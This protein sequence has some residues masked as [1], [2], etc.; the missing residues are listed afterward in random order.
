MQLLSRTIFAI[1]VATVVKC[2]VGNQIIVQVAEVI[3]DDKCYDDINTSGYSV[4]PVNICYA[5][6]NCLYISLDEALDNLTNNVLIN[7]TTNVTLS[8]PYEVSNLENVSI[9]GHNNPT[10]N[11]Q[12]S[13]GLHFIFC[14]NCI[15][16]GITWNRCGIKHNESYAKPGLKF[17]NSSDVT[18][19]YCSFQDFV[20]QIIVMSKISGNVN[21][22][23]CKFANN[24][25]YRGHGGAIH[26]SSDDTK[27]SL[28]FVITISNCNFSFNKMK[29][30]VYLDNSGL[31]KDNK[32]AYVNSISFS[33]NTGVPI[34]VINHE[35]YFNEKVLFQHNEAKYGAGIYIT[36]H[37]AVV[38]DKTSDI[39]FFANSAKCNG[40]AVYLNNSTCLFDKNSSVTF[41]GN[42]AVSYGGTIFSVN[43]SNVVFKESCK[44]RFCS[45][46]FVICGAAIASVQNS[47]VTFTDNAKVTFVNNHAGHGTLFSDNSHIS[48]AG[49][50]ITTFSNNIANDGGGAISIISSHLSFK[51]TSSTE[52]VNNTSYR[53]GGT[54]H[55]YYETY[56]SFEENS[57]AT[58]TST[59]GT[60][61]YL[62]NNNS[63]ISFKG[64]SSTTFNL[65]HDN[66]PYRDESKQVTVF[67]KGKI[68]FEGSSSTIFNDDI[69]FVYITL[70]A[71]TIIF[72]NNSVVTYNKRFININTG[73][74]IA[75]NQIIEMGYSKVVIN[76]HLLPWCTTCEYV[77]FSTIFKY[78]RFMGA[79]II[80][81]SDTKVHCSLEMPRPLVP[82]V[83][84][85]NK[86]Q[87]E[88]LEYIM[89]GG[90]HNNSLNISH[91]VV[92]LSSFNVLNFSLIGHNTIVYCNQS[93][94][95]QVKSNDLI[96]EGITWI[97]CGRQINGMLSISNCS[98]ITI[99]TCSFQFSEGQII[100]ITDGSRDVHINDCK[101]VSNK[102]YKDHGMAILSQ[103][104][105]FTI[106]NC[107][108]SSNEGG[109]SVIYFEQY[110]S[111]LL[112]YRILLINSSFC[113]N[114]GV[115]I[116][117]NH[118]CKLQISG[119]A[120]FDNNVAKHG[121]GIYINKQSTLVFGENSNATFINNHADGS[122]AAIL[123]NNQSSVLFDNN[124]IVMLINN[125][126]T[127]GIIY[128]KFNSN[129]KFK[130]VS[131]V[132]FSNNSAM[133]YG[134]SIYSIDSSHVL[135]TENSTVTFIG[136]TANDGEAVTLFNNSTATVEKHSILT[137]SNNVAKNSGGALYA[138]HNSDFHF[139]DKSI[140][141]FVNN[142]AKHHGET[143]YLR[144]NS[145]VTINSNVRMNG[146][147]ATW[148]YGSQLTNESNYYDIT[149]DANG[150]VRCSDHK[151]YYI[152]TFTKCSCKNLED[153]SSNSAVI[154]TG[155]L[156]LSSATTLTNIVNISITGY[157]NNSIFSTNDGGLQ[158]ISCKKVTITN[159]LFQHISR[160]TYN[161]MIP[162]I[163]LHN[164][165][166]VTI[167][168]CTFLLS[169][170]QEV[171]LSEVSDV[172]IKHC[173][174]E[175]KVKHLHRQ[176]GAAIHYSSNN[177]KLCKDQFLIDDCCF[178]DNSGIKSLIFLEHLNT[179][180][181]FEKIFIQNSK[182][183]KNHGT[184][185]HLL[186]QNLHVKGSLQFDSNL[187]ENG[188]SMFIDHHSNITFG[189]TANV[190]FSHNTAN[191]SGGA[192]YLNNWSSV[193]FE[194]YSRV[195]FFGNKAMKLGGSIYLRNNSSIT[196]R[197]DSK[198]QFDSNNAEMGG[199]LYVTNN[200]F[201]R[202]EGSSLFTISNSK[203]S[204][205][206]AIYC[207]HNCN[208]SIAKRST[209]T[210]FSNEVEEYGS[211]IYSDVNSHVTFEGNTNVTIN[212]NKAKQ[213]GAMYLCYKSD[214]TF[215]EH[216]TIQFDG[217]AAESGG[218]L[219]TEKNSSILVKGN[220]MLTINNSEAKQGGAIYLTENSK[221][222]TI[223][224]SNIAFVNNEAEADGG[225]IYSDLNSTISF[226]G[227]STI[228]I[229]DNRATHGG[230]FYSRQSNLE[231]GSSSKA[232]FDKN[233]AMETGGSINIENYSRIQFRGTCEVIFRN[234]TVTFY[235]GMGGAISCGSNSFALFEEKSKVI[236]DHNRASDGGA[237]NF[238]LNSSF[239]I[240]NNSIVKF[241]NN[242]A[243]TGGAV[244]VNSG[245]YCIFEGN[246]TLVLEHNVASNIGG[247]FHLKGESYI[248]FERQVKVKLNTSNKAA[249][250]GAIYCSEN[251]S[252]TFGNMSNTLLSENRA[253]NGGGIF[254]T[255]SEFIFA[256]HSYILFKN[257]TASQN[258]GAIY[259]NDDSYLNLERDGNV[260]FSH[261]TAALG[262][263]IHCSENSSITF[264]NMSNTL[265]FG[266]SAENGGGIFLA[267]S[268]FI[269]AMHSYI[270]FKNNTAS[271]DGGA[272]YLN[273]NSYLNL[274]RDCNVT[275]SHNTAALGGA[276][277]CSEN[278]S[279]TFGNMS[280]TLLSGNSA[281]NGGGIFLTNSE[282]KFAMHSYIV[283]KN[284]TA[285][286]D[287]GAI[288]LND[289]S[290]LNL[291]RD[292]NVTF[293]HNTAALGGAIHCSENSS[294]KFGNMSNTLLSGNSAENGGGIFL[295][296]SEFIF[297]IHSYTLFKNNTASQDGGA[298]YLNDDS[299]LNLERD[300]NVTF[301]HNTAALGGAIHCSE[302]S[303]ITFGNM[304][305]TLLS[306][307][308]AENG[309]GIFL[310]NSEF[311]FAM[312]SYILFKNNTASQ[313]GGAIYLNDDSHL[314]LERDC[315]VTF[316]HNTASYYGGAMYGKVAKSKINFSSTRIN[317]DSNSAGTEGNSVYITLPKQCN[318]D[319]LSQSIVGTTDNS[320][321]IT[322][323]IKIQFYNSNI[324]CI[325]DNANST[326]CNIYYIKNIMLGQQ[327]VLDACMYDYY[328]HPA[329]AARFLI[330]GDNTQGY[331][332]GS[333]NT[334]ISCNR[335]FELVNIHGN[336]STP[337]NY[338][339][340]LTLYDYCQ[341]ELRDVFTTLIV[342]L[343]SCHSGF[344]YNAVSQKC[345]CYNASDI[346]F[347]SGRSSTI[348]AGYWF[349]S[350]NGKSTVTTCPINYCDFTCCETSN[351][352]YQLSPERDDQ[353]RQHRFDVACGNCIDGYTLSFD[354]T[355]CVN[356]KSCTAGQTAL[357]ILLSMTYWAVMVMLV[358]AMMYYT[359]GIG[360][361]YSITYYYSIVDILLSQN[362]YASRGLYL[363][364]NIIS[365]FSKI[366]PQFLGE[367][368]LTTGMTGID[369]QFIH[370]IHPTAIILILILIVLL[371]KRSR[372][373]SAIIS[374]GIIHVICLLLLLSY[375]SIA[376]TSL[377]LMRPLTFFEIDNIYTYVSPNI[378][379]FHGR[380][381][382]YGIVALLCAVIV[383][384][385]LPFLLI[386][387]PFLNRKIDFIKIKP[388]LDQFQGCYKDQ[389]RCFAGYYMI[390]RL[391]I[392]TILIINSSN[393][394]SYMLIAVCGII[395]LVHVLVKPYNNKLLNRFDSIILQLII[396][397]TALPLFDDID[398]SLVITVTFVLVI[399]PLLNFIAM[400]LFLNKNNI[401]KI[402]TRFTINK[403]LTSSCSDD[404]NNNDIAMKEFNC[405]VDDSTRE[406]VKITV[407]DM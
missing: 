297:A 234:S 248:E 25:R 387:E 162:S 105:S 97:G 194:N 177:T 308:N 375:T 304:S 204:Y 197:E 188:A 350:V 320:Y 82:Y 148:N 361:L 324:K 92:S 309:G 120:L 106:N 123:M 374:R 397:I 207:T 363:T 21:I 164:S 38:F 343:S 307:N 168:N 284:N 63:Y 386:L 337:F 134:A 1:I 31:C 100:N 368:C 279:I 305:N 196:V 191:I 263:A 86:C 208:I 2:V 135:F 232:E 179:H 359:V 68:Y 358:F 9:I 47:H 376:S 291:E 351:G 224:N 227:N 353:C 102:N 367:L 167:E 303:S 37:S 99:Q 265:L 151:E 137:F 127:D 153:I 310:T 89:K 101:F 210:F 272:I 5:Y 294:I 315:N 219:H 95:L 27:N 129:I 155:D 356:I 239:M 301:S 395:S 370:Y 205:G 331:S 405:I 110:K 230:A 143:M 298:I 317:F 313:D 70:F 282:F 126:A 186:N 262:G 81:N 96:I 369:Q 280:I 26:F 11:C 51:G 181:C 58:F 378:E 226:E 285:S 23:D 347:C 149:I 52:F 163:K 243:I 256:M 62:D 302:S 246:S 244:N 199:T 132:I 270:L 286:Q 114:K 17:S 22:T 212:H 251:S 35:I 223:E 94:E 269:F 48:F 321:I 42:K 314:N 214:I 128:A 276:I 266:N 346:V 140:A 117:L 220:S 40:G 209:V 71:E 183:Y 104:S 14:Q 16:K 235:N 326:T 222:I 185:I 166:D 175:S 59:K 173:K 278:S 44:V 206:G 238:V 221:M 360:Y 98:N 18:I 201:V 165:S 268:E 258:G 229:T 184:C 3:N 253:E 281:K 15:V 334:L 88:S 355:K 85:S 77:Q 198:V 318:D 228:T 264:G 306:G 379:Y 241:T 156:I 103:S 145:I 393:I 225:C 288:Y 43:N 255:N 312:H 169:T 218:A 344:H 260:T 41:S 338:S 138:S 394:T 336:R 383:A 295:T 73:I 118:H 354:C 133:Q 389:Y 115:S 319:C 283:F 365:S 146:N 400:I 293:S 60:T 76:N 362:L 348:K 391:V 296:N 366:T 333:N 69:N 195:N 384:V 49:N 187:A 180:A 161:G 377:L 108:F 33:N 124:S 66:G 29:S 36:D 13:G 372:R 323:P 392:I 64:N 327:I 122:G 83:C 330:N 112:E 300:C 349:G 74:F 200:S 176:H 257:N 189:N 150:M 311:I 144:N 403:E 45:T 171:V 249:L 322:S 396:L 287:G 332:L 342:E 136:N 28:Q 65:I 267:N 154:I 172:S 141:L 273:D 245:S 274:E 113:N 50:S 61:I 32:I 250:G 290:Y 381:L 107:Y 130:A 72:A 202:T 93:S 53:Y 80:I 109:R 12:I 87:C 271:Q 6:G 236:F 335:T 54:I 152:C 147:A 237:T 170:G 316:S 55:S 402:I 399:L 339:L 217:N 20:G 46:T 34:Y 203:A 357:V 404:V 398:S 242:S 139:T 407:C 289:D 352:Y 231:F 7:I 406:N 79:T 299:Y 84:R 247:A 340:N 119:D 142:S 213:G 174:F 380:H 56:L 67:C 90:V 182:F 19:S 277:H 190:T 385:G 259:L 4:S 91:K 157:N 388:L 275:F 192:I 240:K 371:A 329:A 345:E 215:C 341:S 8:L 111:E 75:S 364:V 373:I 159:L 160:N 211:C 401:K 254:L 30:I 116:Y 131:R 261:N 390:C 216:T 292:C 178:V 39:M 252:I 24:I 193:V 57:K 121:T 328:G 382:A 10:V 158:F 325:G 125:K 233:I 78:Y